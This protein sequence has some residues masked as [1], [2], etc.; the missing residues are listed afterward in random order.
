MATPCA[1][2]TNGQTVTIHGRGFA[3]SKP[4]LAVECIDNAS[5]PSDCN[6]APNLSLTNLPQTWKPN[7]DGTV[8]IGLK[9]VQ[10]FNGH[11]CSTATP[12]VVSIASIDQSEQP[13][14]PIS[15]R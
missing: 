12:C 11:T 3:P 13:S 6:L 9:V 15:F 4:V 14:A 5:G 2:L 10:Q 8:T 7:A 1:G